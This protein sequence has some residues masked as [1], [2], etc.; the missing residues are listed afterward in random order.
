M[1]KDEEKIDCSIV[2]GQGGEGNSADNEDACSKSFPL[3]VSLGLRVL[4]VV[5]LL[6]HRQPFDIKTVP[7]ERAGATSD[8]VNFSPTV[9]GRCCDNS[10]S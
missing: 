7:S 3:K 5:L 6:W 4:S 2:A 8:I 10:S 1:I 9:L